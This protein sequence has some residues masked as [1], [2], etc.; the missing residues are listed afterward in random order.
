MRQLRVAAIVE[1]HG[2]YASIRG[3]LTRIWP[4]L[5]GEYIEVLQPIRQKRHQL[6]KQNGLE[7]AI[8]LAVLK[9]AR[10]AHDSMR[11]VILVL[12]DADKDLP[13]RLAPE[14][15]A[16]AKNARS[17]LDVICIVAVTVL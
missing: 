14:L 16:L 7:R 8:E 6:V 4:N 2:E 5:G 15:L 13:C 17:D 11:S 9:L 3:L 1:G 12:V 10:A